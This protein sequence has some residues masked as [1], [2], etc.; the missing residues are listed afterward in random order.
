[1]RVTPPVVMLTELTGNTAVRGGRVRFATDQAAIGI[2]KQRLRRLSAVTAPPVSER[3]QC[4]IE[5]D[6][7]QFFAIARRLR[8]GAAAAE[9]ALV[10]RNRE[11]CSTPPLP[12]RLCVRVHVH[13]AT[14]AP[15]LADGDRLSPPVPVALRREHPDVLLRSHCC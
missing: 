4:S 12:V 3:Y 15:G 10:A 11:D 5:R 7:E 9:T 8:L 6:I 2:C 1:M 13:R 14:R